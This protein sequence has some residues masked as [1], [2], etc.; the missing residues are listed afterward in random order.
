MPKDELERIQAYSSDIAEASQSY[1]VSY[2][3]SEDDA[4]DQASRR[5]IKALLA[6]KAYDIVQKGPKPLTVSKEEFAEL[7]S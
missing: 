1:F 4:I 6:F 2:A 5:A 3:P 7:V